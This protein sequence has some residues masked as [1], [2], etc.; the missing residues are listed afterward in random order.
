M[1]AA[2]SEPDVEASPDL[3]VHEDEVAES[4]YVLGTILMYGGG[5]FLIAY[6]VFM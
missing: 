3:G 4:M 6:F 5:V 1:A 2:S